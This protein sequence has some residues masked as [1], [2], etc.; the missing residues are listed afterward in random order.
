MLA[1]I[2]MQNF[3][4]QYYGIKTEIDDAVHRVLESQEF[5]LGKEVELF[6]EAICAW[7]GCKHAIGVSSGTDALIMALMAVGVG[8]GD[9]VI[10]PAYSFVSTATCVSRLGAIPVFCDIDP[11]TYNID[12]DKMVPLV[13]SKTKAIVPVHIAGQMADMKRI[14]HIADSTSLWVIEDAC[15]AIGARE[16]TAMAGTIGDIGCFSFYPS[17]NLGGY[18]DSGM[19]I[20]NNEDLARRLRIIRNH[21]QDYKYHSLIIGGNFRMDAIQGAVLRVKLRHLVKWNAQRRYLADRYKYFLSDVNVGLPF[22]DSTKY[23]VYHL[24]ITRHENRDN[25]RKY[26]QGRGIDTNIYYPLTLPD[27]P[28]YCDDT[29]GKSFPEA[30]RAARESLALPLYPELGL[31]EQ[32]YVSACIHDFMCEREI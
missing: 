22:E 16:G 8:P 13:N 15:Q 32:E 10:V 2:Q 29:I 25:I 31:S 19:V 6:E 7:M 9:E 14:R 3:K 4:V 5:I 20:T 26:L 17:K 27:Q 11:I 1:R 28:I 21:G 12:V 18:G 24:F 23:H 30:R